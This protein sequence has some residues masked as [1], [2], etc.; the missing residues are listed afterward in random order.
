MIGQQTLYTLHDMI[1][2]CNILYLLWSHRQRHRLR[3]NAK[4]NAATYWSC[5]MRLVG[6]ESHDAGRMHALYLYMGGLRYAN[7]LRVHKYGF[8]LFKALRSQTTLRPS[9]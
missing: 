7:V 1:D 6:L 8:E 2:T 9:H 5:A 4:Q 3:L